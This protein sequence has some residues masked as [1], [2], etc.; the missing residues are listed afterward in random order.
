M[1]RD[2]VIAFCVSARI[3]QEWVVL[4]VSRFGELVEKNVTQGE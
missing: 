4:V 1:D 2:F 3:V